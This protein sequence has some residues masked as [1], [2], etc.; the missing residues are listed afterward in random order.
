MRKVSVILFVVLFGCNAEPE[1]IRYGTDAC[2]SCKMTLMDNKFG[3]E[4][5]TAKGKVYKFDDLNC[6][7]GFINSGYLR[8]ET[9]KYKLVVDYSQPGKF[10]PVDKA[11]YLK[12]SDIR[13]PMASGVAAFET[14][15]ALD[16]HKAELNGIQLV[17]DEVSTQFK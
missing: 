6:M 1:A 3:A 15:Q 11:F 14:K 7:V 12:S 13:S 16:K 17:W 9:I 8:D 10:T 2:Y 5:V 4:I